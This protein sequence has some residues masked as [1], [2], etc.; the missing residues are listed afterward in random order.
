MSLFERVTT[1]SLNNPLI[2]ISSTSILEYLGAGLRSTSGRSVSMQTA[3]T[4]SAVY[5]SIAILSLTGGA[6][7]FKT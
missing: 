3:M 5:R 7:P 2:P 1:R 4:M 6:L